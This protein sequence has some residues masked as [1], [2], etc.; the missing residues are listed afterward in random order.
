MKQIL[1][2]RIQRLIAALGATPA[3]VIPVLLDLAEAQRQ[4]TDIDLQALM[5]CPPQDRAA[6]LA[7]FSRDALSRAFR[8]WFPTG[9]PEQLETDELVSFLCAA[10]AMKAGA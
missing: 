6:V 1:A 8:A 4:A 3:D 10:A 7:G 5:N 9:H 2:E